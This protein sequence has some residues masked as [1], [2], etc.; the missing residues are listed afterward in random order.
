MLREPARALLHCPPLLVLDEP[1]IGLN[2]GVNLRL[3]AFLADLNRR[4]GTTVLLTNYNLVDIEARCPRVVMLDRARNL[5]GG[6][7]E[8]FRVR[9]VQRRTPRLRYA[10]PP[11]VPATVGA[12]Q[13]LGVAGGTES[14]SEIAA[15]LSAAGPRVAEVPRRVEPH[16]AVHELDVDQPSV[17]SVVAAIYAWPARSQTRGG[18]KAPG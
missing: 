3:R 6:M 15:G 7:P 17:E 2:T 1:T 9:F 4:Q 13:A 18:D 5:I 8:E 10:E 11:D 14:R 12:L 16:A